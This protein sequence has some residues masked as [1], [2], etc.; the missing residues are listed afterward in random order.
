MY[1]RSTQ[2]SGA[3]KT[4]WVGG[5]EPHMDEAFVYNMFDS[6]KTVL[7]NVKVIR[8]KET[9][10]A[11]GYGFA[12]FTSPAVAGRVLAQLN[13]QPIP[14]SVG[15]RY[16]LN[17]AQFGANDS[18]GGTNYSVFVGDL[19]AETNDVS[20]GECFMQRY[21]TVMGARVVTDPA[22][23]VSKGY[24]FVRFSDMMER[25]RAVREMNGVYLNGR[26]M[27]VSMAVP[28][29]SSAT[30]GAG[31]AGAANAA[32]HRGGLMVSNIDLTLSESDLRKYFEEY[33]DVT[34]LAMPIGKGVATVVM[35]DR[36][37]AQRAIQGL[38]GRQIGKSC[39]RVRWATQSDVSAAAAYSAMYQYWGQYQ[40]AYPYGYAQYYG[41]QGYPMQAGVDTKTTAQT[42]AVSAAQTAPQPAQQIANITTAP[43]STDN[44]S[45]ENKSENEKKDSMLNKRAPRPYKFTDPMKLKVN[46]LNKQYARAHREKVLQVVRFTSKTGKW[47]PPSMFA[48]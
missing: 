12:E 26:G 43:Q 15:K 6:F 38:N 36:N 28:K 34:S 32:A 13:N 19:S 31:G 17:W 1:A 47:L 5:L 25:D 48:V 10:Q 18:S 35:R 40:Y 44:D 16:R 4:L 23:G 37:M 8:D 33:G 14:G 9:G 39:F 24:G 22:T 3:V 46:K 45:T 27:R 29:N 21:A 20:L 30:D 2:A 41:Q 42:T 11:A 7:E